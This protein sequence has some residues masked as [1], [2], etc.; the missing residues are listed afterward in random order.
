MAS[1]YTSYASDGSRLRID[2][3]WTQDYATNSSYITLSAYIENA[4]PIGGTFK[5]TLTIDG[6][7]V[8]RSTSSPIT[9]ETSRYVGS[10]GRT[11][12]HNSDG[13]KQIYIQGRY[14]SNYEDGSSTGT[15][16]YTP[17][18]LIT[19]STIPQYPSF[20]NTYIVEA[21]L[22]K[23]FVHWEGNVP[24]NAQYSLNEGEWTGLNNWSEWGSTF[25]VGNL[26]P[27]KNYNIRI[28]IT[29]HDNGLQTI[30][31]WL[32]FT[33]KDIAMVTGGNNIT[34]EQ[35]PYMTFNN[36][37]GASL[38]A[39]IEILNT[40]VTVCT[41]DNIPNTGNYTFVLTQAEKDI[42]YAKCSDSNSTTIRYGITTKVN[43][44]DSYW[45][46]QDRTVNIVNANPIFND[47]IYADVNDVTIALTENPQKVIKGYSKIKATISTA[48]KAAGLK[49]ASIVKY[50]VEVGTLNTEIAY[51]SSATV[52]MAINNIAN[53]NIN[54]KAIDSRGNS[55][56]VSKTAILI[57]YIDVI[58]SSIKFT[59]QGGI[60][61]TV[62]I[63][64]N[65]TYT[66][67]NFGAIT[68][69]VTSIK[70][71]KKPTTTTTWGDWV[72]ITLLFTISNGTFNNKTS[73]NSIAGFTVGISYDI[74]ISV[75]DRLSNIPGSA[76]LNSGSAT[77]IWNRIKKIVGFGK[78]PDNTLEEGS[79]DAAGDIY[80]RDKK[81]NTGA[82]INNLT[83]LSETDNLSSKMG[84]FLATT[85]AI[86]YDLLYDEGSYVTTPE[87][88]STFTLSKNYT[89]YDAI[90]MIPRGDWNSKQSIISFAPVLDSRYSIIVSASNAN[91][92][93]A[94][95]NIWLNNTNKVSIQCTSVYGWGGLSLWRV[96]GI[97]FKIT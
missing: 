4:K 9:N 80:S 66:N 7:S 74:E 55:T 20:K 26:V 91:S 12:Q 1:R 22:N 96:Y 41:R 14:T 83:N 59:R 15:N 53:S 93:A 67:V 5:A 72:D 44:T 25:E 95:G 36:P 31:D 3:T 34:D 39:F 49:G 87:N 84:N 54:V 69:T 81:V 90:L 6:Q 60:G 24:C 88:T 23:V 50:R 11:I 40:T 28:R 35:N 58:L 45:N 29:R 65:G 37:S 61:T 32:G 21:T 76:T 78:I 47:F 79:I 38:K 62:D 2:D 89:D 94:Y 8:V 92:Y 46:W 17:N 86:R 33:T 70:Y 82:T 52:E 73:G 71:R 19:F 42:I 30:S 97:K 57:E 68:N 51:S 85:S 48:N 64:A 16:L 18:S 27:N 13:N 43:G 56:I 63:I 75:A 10:Y 77:M